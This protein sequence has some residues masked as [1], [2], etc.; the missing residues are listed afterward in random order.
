MTEEQSFDDGLCIRCLTPKPWLEAPD[1]CAVCETASTAGRSCVPCMTDIKRPEDMGSGSLSL[2][3]QEDGDWV[4]R[5]VGR[6]LAD[7][8]VTCSIEFCAPLTGGGASPKTWAALEQ[9]AQAML[10][11]NAAPPRFGQRAEH[12][13]S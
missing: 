9:L 8:R 1:L 7:D 10:E 13:E 12:Y 6:N 5:M 4:V 3:K 2:F 11:D